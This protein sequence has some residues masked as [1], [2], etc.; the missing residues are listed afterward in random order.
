MAGQGGV[1]RGS[2]V[3]ARFGSFN[4]ARVLGLAAVTGICALAGPV[5]AETLDA[6][7]PEVV[8]AVMQGYGYRAELE[9][10]ADGEAYIGSATQGLNFEV[11]FYFC[12][13]GRDCKLMAFLASFTL[14]SAVPAA[15]ADTWNQEHIFG[16]AFL[17]QEPDRIY[18][19]HVVLTEGGLTRD[20]L[21]YVLSS[22][23]NVIVEFAD[24]IGYR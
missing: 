5:A 10:E 2:G 23:N 11:D 9:Y 13:R 14:D 21:A 4:W 16:R 18:I 8:A 24:A 22:W 17:G 12:D 7:D 1:V 20:N 3:P 19:D 6:G 15:M